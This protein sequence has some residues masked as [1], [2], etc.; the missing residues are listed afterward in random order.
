MEGRRR[1]VLAV[2]N[3]SLRFCCKLFLLMSIIA[4]VVELQPPIIVPFHGT[5][6]MGLRLFLLDSQPLRMIV[7]A[8]WSD[9]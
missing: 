8:D 6:T 4:V 9:H 5:G 1:R 7:A 2:D 3:L